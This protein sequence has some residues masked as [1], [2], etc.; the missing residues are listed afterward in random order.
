MLWFLPVP[1][2]SHKIW[3]HT[4]KVSFSLALFLSLEHI[5]HP[6]T[7]G[8]STHLFWKIRSPSKKIEGY[9]KHLEIIKQ[10]D[11][12]KVK[13]LCVHTKYE[14]QRQ[15]PSKTN[16]W[17]A[18]ILRLFSIFKFYAFLLFQL[19]IENSFTLI[20]VWILFK[21]A[22]F[23][24][25]FF[26]KVEGCKVHC[27]MVQC[28]DRVRAKDGLYEIYFTSESF[29]IL[30]MLQNVKSMWHSFKMPSK[31]LAWLNN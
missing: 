27:S 24:Q 31:L 1:N 19:W 8:S 18:K 5:I 25:F 28:T 10:D 21:I 30:K 29:N 3:T 16:S 7:R 2:N 4:C 26:C 14:S 17:G 11:E 23:R 6:Q 15:Y 13:Y 20:C 12:N 22:A 9:K